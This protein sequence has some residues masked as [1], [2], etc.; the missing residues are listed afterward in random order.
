MSGD[1]HEPRFFYI[2]SGLFLIMQSLSTAN[3]LGWPP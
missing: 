1:F 2:L 3:I